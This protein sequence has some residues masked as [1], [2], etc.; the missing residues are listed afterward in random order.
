MELSFEQMYKAIIDKDINYEGIFFTAVKTTGIFC[1][2]SCTA[3]K[4]KPEN[5]EFFKST[6]DCIL[7]GYR[8]CKVCHPL[9]LLN[10][11]PGYIKQI[12][13]E[14]SN[15]PSLKFKD[16]DLRQRGIEPNQLRRWF[17]KNHGITFQAYQR[18]FRINSAFKKIQNGAS[19][20]DVAF[21]S[22]FESLSGFGD[23]FKHIFGVSPN[24]SKEKRIIDLKRIE[25]PLGTMYVC[26]VAEGIC[27]LEFTDRKMLETEFKYLS[28]TLNAIIVQGKNPH[29]NLLEEQLK[30]YFEGNRKIFTVPLFTPGSDFQNSVWKT[31][32]EIPYGETKSYKQQAIAIKNPAAVRAV[33]NA[34]GMNKISILVPCHRVIGS[35]GN[36]TGY[37][38][39]IWRKKW[40]LELEKK[41]S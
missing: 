12:L 23:S 27:L 10:E 1:R 2:P 30:E 22:G 31:L 29:F 9:E 35:D 26:G 14:L 25:T 28:K 33:A 6:K 20:T 34:N 32:K 3:R 40:L 41:N 21:N 18:M 13:D 11:T 16:Y 37:G 5:I 19:V 15:D 24:K 17:M 7:K 4:P 39:G 38:G 8:A 36:M